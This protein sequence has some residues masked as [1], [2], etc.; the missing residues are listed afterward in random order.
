MLPRSSQ[1]GSARLTRLVRAGLLAGLIQFVAVC[2]AVTLQLARGAWP[3]PPPV[4][5]LVARPVT[6]LAALPAARPAPL[7]VRVDDRRWL[8]ERHHATMSIDD[9]SPGAGM[10]NQARHGPWR[11]GSGG[12]FPELDGDSEAGGGAGGGAGGQA[13]AAVV[14]AAGLASGQDASSGSPTGAGALD[15]AHATTTRTTDEAAPTSTAPDPRVDSASPT[16]SIILWFH[17][18]P[19]PVSMLPHIHPA[20]ARTKPHLDDAQIDNVGCRVLPVLWWAMVVARL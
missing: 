13:D 5:C 11:G 17:P 12:Y 15:D 18:A 14:P 2:L 3:V 20:R 16:P 6:Q 7:V 1:L 8:S 10:G 19:A 9:R 4:L